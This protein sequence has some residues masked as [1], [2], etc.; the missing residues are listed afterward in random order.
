LTTL[1]TQTLAEQLGICEDI[2]HE[3]AAYWRALALPLSAYF[4]IAQSAA[5]P[6]VAAK[7]AAPSKEVTKIF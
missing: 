4:E 2:A 1:P 3:K 7:P 5:L 6:H